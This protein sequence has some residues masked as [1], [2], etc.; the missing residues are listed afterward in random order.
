[1]AANFT[2]KLLPCV[3]IGPAGAGCADHRNAQPDREHPA[4]LHSLPQTISTPPFTAADTA[5]PRQTSA[6]SVSK[7]NW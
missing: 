1:M 4:K 3:H 2:L 5:S 6:S 7:A